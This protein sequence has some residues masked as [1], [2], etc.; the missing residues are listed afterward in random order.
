MQSHDCNGYNSTAMVLF[1]ITFI[2]GTIV[3]DRVDIF[4]SPISTFVF[5]AIRENFDRRR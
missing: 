5:L 3:G 2:L 1:R 4:L